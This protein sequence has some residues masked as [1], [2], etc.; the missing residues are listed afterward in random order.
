[1]ATLVVSDGFCK[2]FGYE[3]RTQAYSDM[4]QNMFKD[5]HHD[6]TARFTN[7]LLSFGIEGGRL[8]VL[9]R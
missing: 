2:L 3:N 9:Y 7:A 4:D 6:D 5:V 1:M 8:E